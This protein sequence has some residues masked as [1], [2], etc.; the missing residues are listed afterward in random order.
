LKISLEKGTS[1][2]H[3]DAD[4]QAF[5]ADLW[6]SGLERAGDL[7]LAVD[8]LEKARSDIGSAL[9]ESAWSTDLKQCASRAGCPRN[10]PLPY[11]ERRM[12]SSQPAGAVSVGLTKVIAG[13]RGERSSAAPLVA[14]V[15]WMRT[16][17][18]LGSEPRIIAGRQPD[19]DSIGK[20]S[21]R[22]SELSGR[23]RILSEALWGDLSA[24][25]ELAFGDA[26]SADRVA[27]HALRDAVVPLR[28]AHHLYLDIA[29]YV[30]PELDQCRTALDEL[31]EAQAAAANLANGS[32]LGATAFGSA[33]QATH[34]DWP[35]LRD[36]AVWL[37]S[38]LDIHQ[39]ASRI[40]DWAELA[41]RASIAADERTEFLAQLTALLA[42]LQA[43][44]SAAIARPGATDLPVASLAERLESWGNAGEQLSK[45]VAYQTRAK[46]AVELGLGEI[47]E[48][49][50]EGGLA[51]D[52][53]LA[54]FEMTYFETGSQD[55]LRPT[56]KLLTSTVTSIVAQSDRSPISIG[57]GYGN[58]QSTWCVRITSG[59]RL[60]L[61]VR[62]GR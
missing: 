6:D 49:I 39:L 16:L 21:S 3:P 35:A 12:A 61:V 7:A 18:G 41:H 37:N 26:H 43:D 15:D 23:V 62:L 28:R 9:S 34:S 20:L 52:R 58:P 13:C 57:S 2:T 60:L 51:P 24:S 32:E 46:K 36:A 47:V 38:N 33:W 40:D 10:R 59:F 55:T 50:H 30:D 8:V 25:R 31:T 45:W 42:D 54:Y 56:L 44:A 27:L 48:R 19:R 17:R 14:L 11:V 5:T 1:T 22:V 53:A 29:L 4:P